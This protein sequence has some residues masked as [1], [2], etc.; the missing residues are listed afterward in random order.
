[1]TENVSIYFADGEESELLERFEEV[2][3]DNGRKRSE[4]IRAAMRVYLD[5]L[6]A[7]EH[8]DWAAGS[9]AE[10]RRSLRSVIR[11]S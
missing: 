1:M 9:E 8:A 7:T 3:V 11:Q 2:A 5:V 10:L 4:E 6:E